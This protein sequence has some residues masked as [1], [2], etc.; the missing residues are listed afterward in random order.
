MEDFLRMQQ[1]LSPSED[2][3]RE[4]AI[5]GAS[6]TLAAATGEYC[7]LS[8]NVRVERISIQSASPLAMFSENMF[9]QLLISPLDTV[10]HDRPWNAMLAA[11]S[12][13]SSVLWAGRS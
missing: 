1:S 6:S 4:I 8:L 2:M 5:S 3:L 9:C 10:P 7:P 13:T 11:L 12:V